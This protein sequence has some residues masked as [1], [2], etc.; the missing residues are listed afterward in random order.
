MYSVKAGKSQQP[1]AVFSEL[2][3]E[4]LS[5]PLLELLESTSSSKDAGF[6]SGYPLQHGAV[7]LP[8]SLRQQQPPVKVASNFQ[9]DS[10]RFQ[11]PL[12]TEESSAF[13]KE[14]ISVISVSVSEHLIYCERIEHQYFL[15]MTARSSLT[16]Q[17]TLCNIK[18]R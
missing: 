2:L 15:S 6:G 17:D 3:P 9:T 11:A 8:A 5:C 1:F 10:V 4:P 18:F 14:R 12:L 13:N 16:V 7:L